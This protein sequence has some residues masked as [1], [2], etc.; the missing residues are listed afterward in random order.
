M[1]ALSIV[2][3]ALI[4]AY[5]ATKDKKKLRAICNLQSQTEEAEGM[6]FQIHLYEDD[7]D[8]IV[9]EK[10]NA[11]FEIAEA[12]RSFNNDRLRS[13]MKDAQEEARRTLESLKN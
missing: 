12:R 11:L 7:T 6:N 5:V 10:I 1:L 8:G 13:Q 2:V 9:A 3:A 4:Y